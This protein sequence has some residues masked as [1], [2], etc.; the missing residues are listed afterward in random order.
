MSTVIN[1]PPPPAYSQYADA[2]ASSQ[3]AP[4]NER[5][6]TM[7]TH[8]EKDLDREIPNNAVQKRLDQVGRSLQGTCSFLHGVNKWID[9]N[10][11]IACWQIPVFILKL[12]LR[13]TRNIVQ[14]VYTIAST[15]LYAAVHPLKAL[16]L[17]AQMVVNTLYALTQP[18]TWTKIGAGMI[19]G[20]LAHTLL[21]MNLTAL[22]GA[23]IG[24]VLMLGGITVGTLQAAIDAKKGTKLQAA[25][26]ALGAHLIAIPE[27]LLTGLLMGLLVGGIHKALSYRG[28][29]ANAKEFIK[30]NN[31]PKPSAIHPDCDGGV[32]IY[33]EYD[34]FDKLAQQFPILGTI[35]DPIHHLYRYHVDFAIIIDRFGRAYGSSAVLNWEPDSFGDSY[36]DWT[37]KNIPLPSM[38]L[39]LY[40]GV[41][42]A[43]RLGG[44]LPAIGAVPAARK[45]STQKFALA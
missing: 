42:S 20:S 26:S 44:A 23:G 21:T 14:L 9:S 22:I 4:W 41:W 33:W 8:W 32:T 10:G 13:A 40:P 7:L 24:G 31:L 37:T 11:E 34:Q 15:I 27:A 45:K 12:P 17:I 6:I 39:P 19:G 2:G 43:G 30:E 35:S 3:T 29:V 25:G 36:W 38:R 16:L 5:L 1:D 18:L 28:P